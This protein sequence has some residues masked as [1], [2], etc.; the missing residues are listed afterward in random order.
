MC[1]IRE[2][3][4][5]VT[6]SDGIWKAKWAVVIFGFSCAA[7]FFS[8][9][10]CSLFL[11]A[12]QKMFVDK[13]RVEC[14]WIMIKRKRFTTSGCVAF[15][16]HMFGYTLTRMVWMIWDLFFFLFSFMFRICDG[17]FPLNAVQ[18]TTCYW[19]ITG[20]EWICMYVCVWLRERIK[21][22][23]RV[24]KIKRF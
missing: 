3:S 20:H 11:F 22:H 10:F 15:Q 9:S 4:Q 13:E 18:L 17:W 5:S 23:S 6:E 14:L 12:M 21:V 8:E 2:H 16:N 7:F 24:W 19:T 1:F